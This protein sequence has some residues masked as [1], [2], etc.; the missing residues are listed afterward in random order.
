VRKAINENPVVQVAV[1]G[2]LAIGVAFMLLSRMG[3]GGSSSPASPSTTTPVAA[4]GTATPTTPSATP[5][6]AT[7]PSASGVTTPGAPS[8]AAPTE[9]KFTPGRGLP[10]PVVKAYKDDKIVVLLV[11]RRG[12]VDDAFLKPSSSKKRFANSKV[13]VFVVPVKHVAQYSRITQGVDLNRTPALIVL[14]KKSLT[15]GPVPKASISYGFRGLDSIEQ[16]LRDARYRGANNL[17][18]YPK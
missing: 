9:A 5:P 17:P 11:L 12:G 13:T 2:V 7:T 8:T 1:I 18:Y 15:H 4:A 14:R 10:A 6:A 16:A 3:G